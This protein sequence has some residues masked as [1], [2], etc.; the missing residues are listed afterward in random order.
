MVGGGRGGD[1]RERDPGGAVGECGTE[2][3]IS[4]AF[5]ILGAGPWALNIYA[6]SE[7]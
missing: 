1:R 3:E 7:P 2:K 4:L 5:C 6:N